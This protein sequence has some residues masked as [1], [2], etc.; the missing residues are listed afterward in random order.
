[1]KTNY[2]TH[3]LRCQHAQGT[4]EDYVLSAINSQLD[5][6]G[7]TDHAPFPDI[8]FG[9]RMPYEE[10]DAYLDTIDSLSCKY[11]SD[12]VLLK[13]LEIEYIPDYTSYYEDLLSKKK[14]DYLL[15]GEHIFK[16][17]DGSF[18]NIACA[19]STDLYLEYA[20]AVASALDTGYFK[21]VAHPDLFSLNKFAWD[22]NSDAATDI[23]LE[24]ALRNHTILEYNA[25][26]FRRG[27]VEYPD[28]SRYQ[29]PDKRFWEKVVNSG[30]QVLV[31]SDCHNP[32]QVWDQAVDK[33]YEE[34][35]Q[36]GLQPL[37]QL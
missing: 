29:Y 3:T 12:L 35:A 28:G 16:V 14:L 27:I 10:L 11:S 17:P 19:R 15:L 20:H 24:A 9:L 34:L 22:K 8:D 2:H 25:N 7:F 5:I 37:L 13:S 31:G 33:A 26:G 6:L 18:Q 30:V 36:L 32:M 23:I 1:M 4:E 21:I